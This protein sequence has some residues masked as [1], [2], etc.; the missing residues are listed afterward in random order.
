MSPVCEEEDLEF[1]AECTGADATTC[2]LLLTAAKGDVDAAT[3]LHCK[4]IERG[5]ELVN[6]FEVDCSVSEASGRYLATAEQHL[7][8]PIWEH[9]SGGFLLIRGQHREWLLERVQHKMRTS[10]CK[11]SGILRSEPT[12]AEPHEA[13]WV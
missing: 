2:A 4:H 6:C 13:V 9:P 3:L 5:E 8:V 12:D 11:S 10:K 7:G 1:L